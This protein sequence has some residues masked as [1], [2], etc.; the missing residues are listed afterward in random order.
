MSEVPISE[1]DIKPRDKQIEMT[2]KEVIVDRLDQA[3]KFAEA[4]AFA[5]ETENVLERNARC[6]DGGYAQEQVA[7][8]FARAGADGGYVEALLKVAKDNGIE[9][10]GEKALSVV[11]KV[12]E[13]FGRKF[14]NH[15]DVHAEHH[16]HDHEGE[17]SE[18]GCGHEAKAIQFPEEYGVDPEAMQE[19]VDLIVD[20]QVDVD[21]TVL[22]REHAENAVLIVHGNKYSL[23]PWNAEQSEM[24]FIYDADVDDQVMDAVWNGVQQEISE[25]ASVEAA[26]FKK[27]SSDQTGV[28]VEK[29]AT[30]KGKPVYHVRFNEEGVPTVTE[31]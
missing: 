24:N 6:V 18:I 27:A 14:Q 7:G 16:N 11:K 30:S 3:Q 28:T 12:I 29:L 5:V 2:F 4:N 20:G 9:L 31:N 15:T 8:S 26:E 1:Q 19:V 25:F 22:D 23:Y 21:N 10:S 17:H 13:G